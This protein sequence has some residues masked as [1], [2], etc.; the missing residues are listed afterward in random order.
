MYYH[1]PLLMSHSPVPFRQYIGDPIDCIVEEIPNNVMDTY[2]WIH[3]TFSVPSDPDGTV[4]GC[5]LHQHAGRN[6]PVA[7]GCMLLVLLQSRFKGGNTCET[8]SM[9]CEGLE[10][11]FLT[12]VVT[13][14]LCEYSESAAM[15]LTTVDMFNLRQNSNVVSFD[16]SEKEVGSA[17]SPF[18]N[19]IS[20]CSLYYSRS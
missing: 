7:H 15:I 16:V 18:P 10:L 5:M 20:S 17:L 14:V 19:L 4:G 3:S 8:C 11:A 9:K 12:V 13:D 6:P 1:V 2:C